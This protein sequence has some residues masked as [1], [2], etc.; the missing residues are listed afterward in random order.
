MTICIDKNGIPVSM[1]PLYHASNRTVLTDLCATEYS[2]RRRYR[3][4][5]RETA[6]ANV[7]CF[8]LLYL[9]SSSRSVLSLAIALRFSLQIRH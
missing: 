5:L 8:V 9:F 3:D 2:R 1:L 6:I 4:L 7:V